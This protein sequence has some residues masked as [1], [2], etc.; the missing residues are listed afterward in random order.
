[1]F[2][3][4]S[5]FNSY[6]LSVSEIVLVL[7]ASFLLG[8]GKAGIKGL[9]VIIVLLMAIVF[10][11]KASTGILIPMM[12]FADILAVFYYHQHAQWRFLL[13]LLPM[14]VIGVLI[15]VWLGNRIS[16]EFFKKLMAVF[17]LVAVVIMFLLD[18]MKTRKIPNNPLFAGSMGLFSGITSM[19]GN[20]AGSFADIYFL[21]MRLPKNEFIGTAAWLFLIINVFKLPFHIFSWQTVSERSLFLNLILVPVIGLGFLL[22]VFIVKKLSNN[23]YR[24]FIF[25]ATAIGAIFLLFK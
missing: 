7:L 21:A 15:G 24:K 5:L 2:T 4:I 13:K 18:A 9:G 16:P 11:S 20:L 19:I 10:E 23:L 12:V 8:M 1:M 22:G 6:D 14:M 25:A 3:A 17:I